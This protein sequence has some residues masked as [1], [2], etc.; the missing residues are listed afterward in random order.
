MNE[1][2]DNIKKGL[3]IPLG[4]TAAVIAISLIIALI[5]I[6]ADKTKE[7]NNLLN[8]WELTETFDVDEFGEYDRD[9]S[10]FYDINYPNRI[11]F[12]KDGTCIVEFYHEQDIGQWSINNN[13]L[14]VDN[15][16]SYSGFAN[17]YQCDGYSLIIHDTTL[18]DVKYELS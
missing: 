9:Y 10:P 15:F 5:M 3:I 7:K 14:V 13:Y 8:S 12:L 16:S 11:T 17:E 6:Y 4:F 1:K 18:I 2:K